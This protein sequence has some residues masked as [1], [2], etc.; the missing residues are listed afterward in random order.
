VREKGLK[1]A[2]NASIY[3]LLLESRTRSNFDQTFLKSLFPK[4]RNIE[5]IPGASQNAKKDDEK[6]K[7]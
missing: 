3:E 1:H 5:R 6:S 4:C 2:C 7:A